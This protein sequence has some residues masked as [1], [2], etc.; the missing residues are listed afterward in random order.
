MLSF[1]E[2]KKKKKEEGQNKPEEY[3][4][5]EVSSFESWKKAKASGRDLKSEAL[6]SLDVALET[7]RAKKEAS[8]EWVYS[9]SLYNYSFIITGN[10]EEIDREEIEKFQ[11][12]II[13]DEKQDTFQWETCFVLKNNEKVF[14]YPYIFI[15]YLELD[16][17]LY[18]HQ[19]LVNQFL[20]IDEDSIDSVKMNTFKGEFSDL[21]EVQITNKYYDSDKKAIVVEF[22]G[23][24]KDLKIRWLS[25]SFLGKEGITNLY[26]YSQEED[27]DNYLSTINLITDSFKYD[28]GYEY[29]EDHKVKK[30]SGLFD[31]V[32]NDG[33]EGGLT[34]LAVCII[35]GIFIGFRFIYKKTKSS[36]G[37]D[38]KGG[39]RRCPNCGGKINLNSVFCP[40]CGRR[41][42]KFKNK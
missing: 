20:T 33:I 32:I 21:I 10:W 38:S 27:Y 12:L 31:S 15:H 42:T 2:W 3:V 1:E 35:I 13:K 14:E 39:Q 30:A 17:S 23:K 26:F 29:E 18:S 22:K 36:L 24:M 4:V 9:S 11:K 16:S 19:Q 34:A 6:D 5:G 28:L 40:K 8:I 37:V 7:E 41:L 25:V